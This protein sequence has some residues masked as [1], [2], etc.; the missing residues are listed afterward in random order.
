MFSAYGRWGRGISNAT[1]GAARQKFQ[2]S[3]F[4]GS[5]LNRKSTNRYLVLSAITSRSTNRKRIKK[6]RVRQPCLRQSPPTGGRRP[7]Q[8]RRAPRIRS[9]NPS[10]PMRVD[11]PTTDLRRD[12]QIKWWCRILVIAIQTDMRDASTSITYTLHLSR[13]IHRQVGKNA[14]SKVSCM[15]FWRNQWRIRSKEAKKLGI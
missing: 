12:H 13:V 4:Q 10:I 7:G 15:V 14:T 8:N 6:G 5:C 3:I 11:S 9:E 1:S 2:H